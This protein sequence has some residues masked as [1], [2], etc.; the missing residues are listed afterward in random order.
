MKMC[1]S[2]GVIICKLLSLIA[3]LMQPERQEDAHLLKEIELSSFS[4]LNSSSESRLRKSAPPCS[5][6][7]FEEISEPLHH[8][9]I[10]SLL[11]SPSS[12]LTQF[13]TPPKSSFSS[14]LKMVAPSF[15]L[16]LVG[17]SK[18]DKSLFQDLKSS[19]ADPKY[20]SQPLLISLCNSL[21]SKPKEV[22]EK[23]LEDDVP[24]EAKL[25]ACLLTLLSKGGVEK[26]M[27]QSAEYL[28]LAV[29]QIPILKSA[30]SS[31]F[32]ISVS[33]PE[34]KEEE[35]EKE[36]S[37]K[38]SLQRSESDIELFKV[39]IL[40][41]DT[42]AKV[43]SIALAIL[44]QQLSLHNDAYRIQVNE[45][46][47]VQQIISDGIARTLKESKSL[48][49]NELLRLKGERDKMF[50]SKVVEEEQTLIRFCLHRW[51][52]II[53]STIHCESSPAYLKF[54]L[55]ICR[56][57]LGRTEGVHRQ[58]LRLGRTKPSLQIV[59]KNC[60]PLSLC[61]IPEA[62]KT[63]GIQQT[64]QNPIFGSKKSAFTVVS[65]YDIT[66]V[67]CDIPVS[68]V[69]KAY[70]PYPL[71]ASL[72]PNFEDDI[73][74]GHEVIIKFDS[75][76]PKDLSV[77]EIGIFVGGKLARIIEMSQNDISIETPSQ[78]KYGTYKVSFTVNGKSTTFHQINYTY[79]EYESLVF[80]NKSVER[81]QSTVVQ[82]KICSP[83][84]PESSPS[85]LSLFNSG[86]KEGSIIVSTLL[87]T[88]HEQNEE[89]KE[90]SRPPENEES[91]FYSDDNI[92][93]V[94]ISQPSP[95][96][97]PIQA[98]TNFI[99]RR[100]QLEDGDHASYVISCSRLTPFDEHIGELLVGDKSMAFR[101]QNSIQDKHSGGD[102]AL[103]YH[104]IKEIHCRRY[105]LIN[106]AFELFLF[107]GKSLM[108]AFSSS[109]TRDEVLSHILLHMPFQLI[110][111]DSDYLATYVSSVASEATLA[112]S[113]ISSIHSYRRCRTLSS[114]PLKSVTSLWVEGQI[115]SFQYL[116]ELNTRA[117]RTYNDLNQYPVFPHVIGNYTSSS[118]FPLRLLHLPIG[119]LDQSRLDSAYKKFN[120][121][122]ELGENPFL[123]GTHYS[124]SAIT[125]HYL[126]RLEPFATYHR[127]FQSGR[128]DVPDRLFTTFA[129]T[130]S[131]T[132]DVKELIP[133]GFCLPEM[134]SNVN[135]FDF[136]MSQSG[137]RVNDV[138]LPSW[139]NSPR[140]FIFQQRACL[141]SEEAS[142]SL[143]SWIDLIFGTKQQ[144]IE[145]H[146]VFHPF[147]TQGGVDIS[148]LETME[149]RL[150]AIAQILTFGQTP[151][152]LFSTPH[153]KR[154]ADA[155]K[156]SFQNAIFEKPFD[157][158]SYKMWTVKSHV[159]HLSI[160]G[161]NIITLG[162]GKALLFPECR[163]YVSWGNW[164]NSLKFFDFKGKLI[165]SLP[166]GDDDSITMACHATDGSVLVSANTQ[167]VLT[168]WRHPEAHNFS[169]FMLPFS[170][171]TTSIPTHSKSINYLYVCGHQRIAL[172][173]GQDCLCLVIDIDK[174]RIS[175]VLKHSSPVL[176]ATISPLT[177]D[178]FTIS[179]SDDD[180]GKKQSLISLWSINGEFIVSACIPDKIT[181]LDI[182]EGTFGLWHNVV[183]AGGKS[184]AIHLLSARTL[185]YIRTLA[186]GV[187][188]RLANQQKQYYMGNK[189]LFEP[190]S[191]DDFSKDEI[192]EEQKDLIRV[193][194]S[195]R[196]LPS[197]SSR[198]PSLTSLSSLSEKELKTRKRSGSETQSESQS[199]LKRAFSF[200]ES[201]SQFPLIKISSLDDSRDDFSFSSSP[202]IPKRPLS[203]S[204]NES[205]TVLPLSLSSNSLQS[206]Q[207]PPLASDSPRDSFFGS[208]QLLG[209]PKKA[210]RTNSPMPHAT[211]THATGHQRFASLASPLSN[212]STMVPTSFA[213][214]LK[215]ATK[216]L[217]PIASLAISEDQTKIVCCDAKGQLSCW[218][219]VA[220]KFL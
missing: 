81:I 97:D 5:R 52:E 214:E 188:T 163:F 62:A 120:M 181:C 40:H 93:P 88:L 67:L 186:T 59:T 35:S 27:N 6:S 116:M 61:S 66:L 150:S 84:L 21:K 77:N 37:V 54:S 1:S 71:V 140:E 211:A 102:A 218:S 162:E 16:S 50:F 20:Q 158:V 70:F 216:G 34:R 100:S 133:E 113:P 53:D 46:L 110:S 157:L 187:G 68:F 99:S 112:S 3:V 39:H 138:L 153:P 203:S 185:A 118:P 89:S 83:R 202:S 183:V 144:D 220:Q 47:K 86:I 143:H 51:K 79:M 96:Q 194:S 151:A 23:K 13:G 173:C 200:T 115:S 124:S 164:D 49:S 204:S 152:K 206:V 159:S 193:G 9:F 127:E 155:Y 199:E 64:E 90:K 146:N 75:N 179:S 121:L 58:R 109:N 165:C 55:P 129:N 14:K 201:S 33:F 175:S 104:Q 98:S 123:F 74:G 177:G 137:K 11:S 130:Y 182:T 45:Q 171:V 142:Q 149:Q 147:S 7:K 176:L 131:P 76:F 22:D 106:I 43:E 119:A 48:I 41:N 29:T 128:F 73:K 178:I 219:C 36:S 125:H 31:M 24:V 65:A 154:K 169:P 170:P 141:E 72:S 192:N 12:T 174:C 87:N 145:A 30:L 44:I 189:H 60:Q 78:H 95:S 160:G 190:K 4:C 136:G 122:K 18:Q 139:A 108:F 101:S 135:Q 26:Q 212:S 210:T 207:S 148:K 126:I 156:S 32:G 57:K 117:G 107:S 213:D 111:S 91:E 217:F 8:S 209:T 167:G 63:L 15:L 196:E 103:S 38:P 10:L 208:S 161:G 69:A 166:S 25:L 17:P 82:P 168:F 205:F 92:L 105:L 80:Y 28:W 215:N 19:Q 132:S 195:E 184:G 2:L 197:H 56:I 114:I 134:F 42:S 191:P 94:K 180:E 172:S 85:L 198:S